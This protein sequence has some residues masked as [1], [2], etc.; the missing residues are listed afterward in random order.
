MKR[1]LSPIAS[2]LSA[3]AKRSRRSPIASARE[4]GSPKRRWTLPKPRRSSLR[5]RTSPQVLSFTRTP[6]LSSPTIEPQREVVRVYRLIG[7]LQE[8]RIVRGDHIQLLQRKPAGSVGELIFAPAPLH[9]EPLARLHAGRLLGYHRER[10]LA[11]ADSVD[12]GL[13]IPALRGANEMHV[14]VDEA[15]NHRSAFEVDHPGIGPDMLGHLIV[16]A[17]RQDPVT[18]DRQCLDGREVVVDG[19]N[20]AVPEYLLGPGGLF[21]LTGSEHAQ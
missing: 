8:Q 11:R 18:L 13:E 7:D 21:R 1:R 15:R 19:Q 14:I 17:H 20:L 3:R 12:S 5:A 10:L 2:S 4:I 6:P 16:G 9:H